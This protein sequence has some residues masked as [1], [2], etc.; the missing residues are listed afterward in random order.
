[1]TSA[2]RDAPERAADT[3]PKLLMRHGEVR[4]ARAAIR[5][6]D[7]GIWQ[8]WTWRQ[9]ADEARVLAAGLATEG[10]KRGEHFA[11]V[12]DNR[13]RLYAAMAA[14]QCLG[15]IP[16]PLYQDAVAAEMA[17]PIQNAAIAFVFAEDQEQVDKLFEILPSCPT[18]KRIYFD[19]P[20]GL[21]HYRQPQ[22]L[23]YEKLAELGRERL[24][25][26]PG[27]VDAEIAKGN[28]TDVA[29]MFF[30]SGTTGVPKGVVHTHSSLIGP[31]R[32]AAQLDGLGE[33]DVILAYLPPAWIGQNIFSCAQALVGGYC[34]CCPE[35]SETVMTDMREVGPTYYFAPPRVL[36]NLLTQVSIRMEDA[37]RL[38]RALFRYFMD[39]ATRVG[40]ALLDGRPVGLVERL[41]YRVGDLVIYGP[42]RN[43]LGMSRV[44]VA[45]TAG[46]AVGPD[47][48]KF[49]RSIGINMKQL[50]GSTETAVF[51]CVQPDGQVK[52]DTVGPAVPG[53]ELKFS[54]QRELL[55]RSPGLFRGYYKNPQATD[56]ALDGE[57]WF[58]TGDAGYIDAD[59]HVKI[60]D[61]VKDVG[62]LAD[63]TLFAPK[64][65]ENKLKFF[66][67]IREAV[68]FGHDRDRVCAF[69]NIDPEAIGN[70]A[71]RSNLPYSGYSDLAAKD[72]VYKLVRECVERVNADLAQ[73][74]ELA[75]S[76]IHRFLILH[77]E[78][79]ADDGEL[80][81]TRKVRRGFIADKYASLVEALYGGRDSVHVEA[82]VRYEDGRTGVYS[83]ELRIQDVKPVPVAPQR[84]AA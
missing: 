6:K 7:L 42:L 62:K 76:Q 53:V 50:Y 36:E 65:L 48:F 82:Q 66:S 44:R 34:I 41:L 51:V 33:D 28:G 39:V 20:R 30:T 26:E 16:V 1:M 46:E 61:R 80:T 72:E 29:A 60:I 2:G 25:R 35:S 77:K 64:F 54:P 59:G 21:R 12:G 47:L 32:T 71:E 81:R 11:L 49:F 31:A 24:L 78:L 68:C 19:D 3:F 18:L 14:A 37:S 56:E 23:A 79:D 63:G 73:E 75:H 83:A 55:V 22:L 40:G 4:G 69:I 74:P 17:F 57:G 58:H 13:P 43:I 15:A 84:K 9:F 5:E 45:Y 38:K 67:Y 70:W 52:P 8:T 10:L 27:L